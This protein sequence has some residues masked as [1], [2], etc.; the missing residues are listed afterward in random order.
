MDLVE[1]IKKDFV[2]YNRE[3][4]NGDIVSMAIDHHQ[5]GPRYSESYGFST[6]KR[7]VVGKAFAMGAMAVGEYGKQMDPLLQAKIKSRINVATFR[8]IKD[9]DLGRLKAFDPE[10]SYIYGRQAEVMAIGGTDPDAV[11]LIQRLDSKGNVIE[12]LLRNREVPNEVLVIEG[13]Y[14]PEE[15]P[16]PDN[17][18]KERITILPSTN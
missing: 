4:I 12:T 7:E 17:R 1:A 15:D 13:R 10:F 14:V 11:M 3:A 2:T 5:T 16:L 18:I 6:S 9:V 8:A